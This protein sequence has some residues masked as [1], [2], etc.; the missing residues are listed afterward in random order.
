[1]LTSLRVDN[2]IYKKV[3]PLKKHKFGLHQKTVGKMTKNV[4]NGESIDLIQHP[5]PNGVFNV[6]QF[7]DNFFV[8]FFV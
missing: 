2:S 4:S 7:F 8:V 6:L 5:K 1:M 3:I